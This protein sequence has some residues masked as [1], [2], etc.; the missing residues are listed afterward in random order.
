MTDLASERESATAA[1]PIPDDF[2]GET[3]TDDPAEED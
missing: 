1:V 3:E 2:D